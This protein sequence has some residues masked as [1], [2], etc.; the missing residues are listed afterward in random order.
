MVLVL[1]RVL[2]N[3]HANSHRKWAIKLGQLM[4]MSWFSRSG[5]RSASVFCCSQHKI[6]AERKCLSFGA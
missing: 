6:C 2:V 1:V 5:F 4:S 3:W